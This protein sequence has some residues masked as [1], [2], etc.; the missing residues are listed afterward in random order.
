L[1]CCTARYHYLGTK[2]AILRTKEHSSVSEQIFAYL[3]M[4]LQMHRLCLCSVNRK[5]Y[6]VRDEV[7]ITYHENCS[8]TLNVMSNTLPDKVKQIN[9]EPQ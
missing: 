7:T 4:L 1:H 9:E 5:N 6:C 8:G 3:T 2:V